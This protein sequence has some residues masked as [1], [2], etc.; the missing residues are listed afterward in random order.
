MADYIYGSSSGC[1]SPFVGQFVCPASSRNDLRVFLVLSFPVLIPLS[2]WNGK[3]SSASL[4]GQLQNALLLF[5][6]TPTQLCGT[7]QIICN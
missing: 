2:A 4:S 7:W 5:L 1:L 6:S 3:S